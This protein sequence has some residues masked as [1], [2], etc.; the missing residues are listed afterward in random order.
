MHWD[1]G[2]VVPSRQGRIL[3]RCS[4][5]IC[6][7]LWQGLEY[8]R[9]STASRGTFTCFLWRKSYHPRCLLGK[10]NY[11]STEVSASVQS[12]DKA[13][14]T[15]PEVE[16]LTEGVAGPASLVTLKIGF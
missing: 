8:R 2:R 6:K 4:P 16:T 12:P 10:P 7:P 15:P 14:S 13:M 9:P 11:T 5:N 3:T 1:E